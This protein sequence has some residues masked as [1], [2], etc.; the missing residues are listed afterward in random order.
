MKRSH[1]LLGCLVLGCLPFIGAILLMWASTFV[2]GVLAGAALGTWGVLLL[3]AWRAR[4]ERLQLL[5]ACRW[6]AADYKIYA[7]GL[8]KR[9]VQ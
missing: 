5:R 6:S 9:D 2:R 4:H 8:I 7:A 1:Y 3:R